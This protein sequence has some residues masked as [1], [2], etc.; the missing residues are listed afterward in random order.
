MAICSV[1]GCGAPAV[2]SGPHG[3]W[4]EGHA[5][6]GVAWAAASGGV[7]GNANRAQTL[8]EQFEARV[9]A[10]EKDAR[11]ARWASNGFLEWETRV[12][13]RVAKQDA[14]VKALEEHICGMNGAHDEQDDKLEAVALELDKVRAL[15][16]ATKRANNQLAA[17]VSGLDRPDRLAPPATVPPEA[18]EDAPLDPTSPCAGRVENMV[19][20]PR[21]V[22]AA[23][24]RAR[25]DA[26]DARRAAALAPTYAPACVVLSAI[27]VL[28]TIANLAA[29]WGPAALEAA[30]T[31]VAALVSLAGGGR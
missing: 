10:L 3:R 17:I 5:L 24:A 21:R 19:H 22:C 12:L 30:W 20:P 16:E 7:P 29:E 27:L 15:A 6:S 8:H 14:R 26:A 2:E 18:C 31:A 23:H 11:M 4:C 25:L 13:E 9:T 28:A 1:S